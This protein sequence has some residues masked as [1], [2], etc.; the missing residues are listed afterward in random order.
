MVLTNHQ[1]VISNYK[2]WTP[3][4][5]QHSDLPLFNYKN[6][7]GLFHH[8]KILRHYMNQSL[9]LTINMALMSALDQCDPAI[10]STVLT[11]P[12]T[13]NAGIANGSNF[14]EDVIGQSLGMG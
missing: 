12:T 1:H 5:Q 4:Q 6:K 11:P 3:P 8:H 14:S 13:A 2:I 9:E 7:T 10:I